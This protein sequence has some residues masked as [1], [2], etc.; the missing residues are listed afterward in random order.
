MQLSSNQRRKMT[1]TFPS[2]VLFGSG[3]GDPGGTKGGGKKPRKKA[4]K[5]KAAKK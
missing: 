2:T 4:G 1:M 3:A 5:K